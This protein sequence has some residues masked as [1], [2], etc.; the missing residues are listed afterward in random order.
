MRRT[1]LLAGAAVLM[2]ALGAVGPGRAQT[3]DDVPGLPTPVAAG[4]LTTADMA[5]ITPSPKVVDGS[6]SDWTGT[7]TGYAGAVRHSAGELVYEDHVFD[8]Y[9]ADNGKDTA[10]IAAVHPVADAVA[11]AWR[12]EAMPPNLPGFGCS[13]VPEFYDNGNPPPGWENAQ[14]TEA[15]NWTYGDARTPPG[16]T[17]AADLVELR[18]A[19]QDDGL[20][21]L[22]RVGQMQSEGQSA[23]VLLVGPAGGEPAVPA[24]P[25]PFNTGISTGF[26]T[27]AVLLAGDGGRVADLVTGATTELGPDAVA[28]NPDGFDNAIEARLPIDLIDGTRLR[29]AAATGYLDPATGQL[30]SVGPATAPVNLV[31]VAFRHEP[32][33]T[34]MDAAQAMALFGRSIDAFTTEV[35]LA[36]LTGGRTETVTPGPGYY[37]RV[38]ESTTN[39]LAIE[40][41]PQQGR[42][43]QYGLYLPTA[44]R[45]GGPNPVT[46]ALHGAYQPTHNYA[47]WF[48]RWILEFGEQRD[49]VVVVPSARG[50]HTMYV[51]VGYADVMEALADVDRDAHLGRDRDRTYGTGYSMGGTGT[52][53]LE[54]LHPDLFAATFHG[55]SPFNLWQ[56]LLYNSVNLRQVWY[57]TFGTPAHDKVRAWG[58]EFRYYDF[59]PVEHA[60][61]VVIDQWA[62]ARDYLGDH[63][64]TE[65]PEEV[66]F[67]RFPAIEAGVQHAALRDGVFPVRELA[68]PVVA[69]RAFWLSG[70]TVRAGDPASL[71][72]YAQVDVTTHGL[73]HR[74]RVGRDE[75]GAGPTPGQLQ[76]WTMQ[77]RTYDVSPLPII[78]RRNSFEATLQNTGRIQLDGARMGLDPAAPVE[79]TIRSDGP[80]TVVVTGVGRQAGIWLNG[81]RVGTARAGQAVVVVGPGDNQ[82]RVG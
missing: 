24:R 53:L 47:S 4:A 15:C 54:G 60:A 76:P 35:D 39:G 9:G 51:G 31:N 1:A 63:R 48:P 11:P 77:G 3:L 28:A 71:A 30:A 17:E 49:N 25:V 36:D 12:A 55:D 41:E 62:E 23:L 73:G 68:D 27:T 44:F 14:G 13:A 52:Q 2:A 75:S 72:T 20:Y 80:T 58:G 50:T 16:A 69:D 6:P 79:A 57:R 64:R 65:N 10:T 38:F 67:R 70:V 40:T 22:G 8:A 56:E 5:T 81:R 33:S 45:P 18:V 74:S 19:A 34:F 46:L 43:Q 82:V 37:E 21:V 66:H 7:R 42:F 29:L 59:E 78:P 61:L 32:V 26:A